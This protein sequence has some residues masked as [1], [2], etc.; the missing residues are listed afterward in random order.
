MYHEYHERRAHRLAATIWDSSGRPT[1]PG[2]PPDTTRTTADR[3]PDRTGPSDRTER[4]ERTGVVGSR[5]VLPDGCMDII[6]S[7][8]ANL[9][10]AGPDTAAKLVRWAP[11]VRHVG[12][13][14]DSGSGPSH[15]GVA[16][17]ELRDQRVPLADLWGDGP[18]QRLAERLAMAADPL[19]AFES[20][21]AARPVHPALVDRLVPAVL[22]GARARAPVDDLARTV[23]LSERQLLRR[24]RRVFGYGPKT[25]AR[26]LRM[27]DALHAARAGIP[28]AV[29]A[30]EAGY[31]DQAHLAREVR[32]LA[33]VPP[34]HLIRN[35]NVQD[36]LD[37]S[38]SDV[39]D[40]AAATGSG[41]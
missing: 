26:I 12:L 24:C 32:A 8:D 35:V 31:A 23:G 9:I 3:H 28:F 21:I 19:V 37:V 14:F 1:P 41:A 5:R 4:T 18:A 10:V 7:S 36:E 29:V 6:W 25:L 17:D 11:G 40:V 13:R 22:A 20:S 39:A 27:Q 16:A 2:H 38:V 34:T 33:G 15:L 30:A